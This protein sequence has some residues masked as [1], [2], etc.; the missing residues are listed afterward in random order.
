MNNTD[1][2]FNFSI[3]NFKEPF[4]A[5]IILIIIIGVS[6]WFSLYLI[7]GIV[8]VSKYIYYKC[9]YLIRK[10]KRVLTV[11]QKRLLIIV[12]DILFGSVI[13]TRNI[14]YLLEN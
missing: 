8:Y 3:G 4:G 14:S 9:C 13:N 6:C 12:Y 11:E 2:S 5:I 7:L 10:L 1:N